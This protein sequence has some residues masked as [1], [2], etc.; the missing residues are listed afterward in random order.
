MKD[1][2]KITL[3]NMVCSGYLGVAEW[4]REVPTRIEVDVE[5][6]ADLSKA[7]KSDSLND[8]IDYSKVYDLVGEVTGRKHYNLLESLANQIADA[9]LALCD[10]DKIVVRVRKPHP[11]ISGQCDYA[12]VEVVRH[13]TN[14]Q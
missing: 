7:C 5:I 11:P 13:N 9:L 3:R 14:R 2:E 1:S 4:E 8:T 10:C 12:E 6:Y